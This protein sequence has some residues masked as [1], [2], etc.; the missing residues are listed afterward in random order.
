[1]IFR[2]FV[3]SAVECTAFFARRPTAGVSTSPAGWWAQCSAT[4]L[5]PLQNVL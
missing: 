3:P 1:M 4:A 5:A 2:L